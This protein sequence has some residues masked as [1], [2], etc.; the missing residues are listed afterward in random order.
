MC[1]YGCYSENFDKFS[2]T[3]VHIHGMTI[4]VNDLKLLKLFIINATCVVKTFKPYC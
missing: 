2:I 4:V 1:F 3:K